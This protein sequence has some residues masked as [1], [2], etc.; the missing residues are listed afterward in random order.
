MPR[1]DDDDEVWED[2]DEEGVDPFDDEDDDEDEDDG[3]F[4]LD[5]D[6]DDEEEG[7]WEE[8]DDDLANVIELAD[9]LAD[10]GESRRALKLWRKTI[11]R[12][13][14]EHEAW[15][16]LGRA[17]FRVL[18]EETEHHE[19]WIDDAEL[20]GLY[21]EAVGALDEAVTIE[22]KH[23]DSWNLL[24][25]LYALRGNWRSAIECWEKSLKIKPG[26]EEVEE[27]LENAREN[28]DAEST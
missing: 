12:F 28:L 8:E 1:F 27:D 2:E 24:G 5:E 20:M 10:S 26:Q 21:E 19:I 7:E 9:D 16:H 22:E 6:D 23:F 17:C 14:E 13:P 18:E 15:F 25:A 4:F 11:E 3:G